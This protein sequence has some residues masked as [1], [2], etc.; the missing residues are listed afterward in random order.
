MAIDEV[1]AELSSLDSETF[2]LAEMVFK[3]KSYDTVKKSTCFNYDGCER[4]AF[5]TTLLYFCSSFALKRLRMPL[6]NK[7]KANEE[8]R[9][10][11]KTL[12]TLDD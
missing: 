2:L 10:N 1:P 3:S 4:I 6:L 7:E 5:K 9:R 8:L 11:W 12:P